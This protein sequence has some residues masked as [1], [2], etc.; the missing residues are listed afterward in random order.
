[1]LK[2]RSPVTTI[3]LAIAIISSSGILAAHAYAQVS[4]PGGAVLPGPSPLPSTP[5]IPSP[6]PIPGGTVPTTGPS[7]PT[8][9][10]T[11]PQVVPLP[12]QTNYTVGRTGSGLVASDSFTNT[13]QSK[14]ELQSGPSWWIYG[15]DAPDENAPYALWR[16]SQG[17]HIGAQAPANGTYAGYYAQTPI[18]SATLYHARVTA[19]VETIPSYNNYYENG[20]YVQNGTM[21][22]NYVT[23]TSV[24]TTAGTQWAVVAANGSPYG[25]TT[26]KSLWWTGMSPSQ[27]LTVDCTI[28]TNGTNYLK[29]L[30]NNVPVYESKSLDLNMSSQ[31]ITFMEPQSNYAG[32][33][34]NGT[35][36]NYYETSG[37]NVTVTNAPPGAAT[38]K[39]VQPTSSGSG[40]VLV[41]SPVDRS[42]RAVLYAENQPMPMHAY[43]IV[44]DSR[45]NA[46]ASTSGA[47]DIWGGDTYSVGG[48]SA[49]YTVSNANAFP[50][51]TGLVAK[52]ASQ[53]QIA[54]GWTAPQNGSSALTG[55]KIERQSGGS[56]AWQTITS[57]TNSTLTSYTDS[58]L[59]PDT[60]YTYRVSAVYGAATSSPSDTASATTLASEYQ[61]TVSSQFDTGG[62]LAGMYTVLANSTG[63]A[64]GSGWTPASFMLDTGANYTVT[65][66]NYATYVFDHWLDTGSASNQRQVSISSNTAL[67]AVF[68]D[69]AVQLSPSSG[70]AGTVVTVNGTTFAPNSA[71]KITFDGSAAVTTPLSVV[72]D[73]NGAFSATIQVPLGA[74]SGQHTIT[75]TDGTSSHSA[76]FTV[77]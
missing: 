24:T 68:R 20:M 34:L 3:L 36:Q 8:Q 7:L 49:S 62:A 25:A 42:G 19:P 17:L 53:S 23:C 60:S 54:L 9:N 47:V 50:A 14:Q 27:Q 67:T 65:I 72:S 33:M 13:T 61:L 45:G 28:I 75:A 29:V 2:P 71:I 26:F 22:V 5:P 58:G 63:Q 57:D 12:P 64:V 43:I 52:A 74:S 48:S 46:M 55:Y 32:Q 4:P 10:S 51:P 31:F 11:V 44:Y 70:A 30:L 73:A 37:G 18:T 35:F 21:D 40:N 15:G 6:S 39:I 56:T 16:D 38:V 59:A 41:S 77:S 1:M 69:T 76:L 66:G